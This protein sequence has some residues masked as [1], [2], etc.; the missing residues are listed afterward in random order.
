MSRLEQAVLAGRLHAGAPVVALLPGEHLWRPCTLLEFTHGGR[1]VVVRP[2]CDTRGSP[3]ASD[4]GPTASD[5]AIRENGDGAHGG[6]TAS[7]TGAAIRG[8]L[9][10]SPAAHTSAAG[11]RGEVAERDEEDDEPV[12][13]TGGGERI[14]LPLDMVMTDVWADSSDG[15]PDG[16]ASDDSGGESDGEVAGLPHRNDDDGSKGDGHVVMSFEYRAVEAQTESMLSESPAAEAGAA[17]T[18]GK[19]P[20]GAEQYISIVWNRSG[21]L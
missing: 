14:S 6:L 19:A 7:E 2:G 20:L 17:A 8:N 13:L 4:T 16:G 1:S 11:S 18:P 5:S 21:A 3:T 9:Y 12:G 10:T 15:E